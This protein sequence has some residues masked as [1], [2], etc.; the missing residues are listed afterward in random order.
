MFKKLILIAL[1]LTV[2]SF[3]GLVAVSADTDVF[4]FTQV[5]EGTFTIQ[6][7]APEQQV[8]K[9]LVEK[10]AKRYFYD[11][12]GTEAQYSLQMGSGTY[13]IGLFRQ[14]E[15]T[16]FEALAYE[17]VNVS[18]K[19]DKV[20]FL[21][22]AQLVNWSA[23]SNA[24]QLAQSITAGATTDQEKVE[25]IY[26]FIVNNISYDFNKAKTVQSG[27]VPNLDMV[28][29][30][31]NGIC[32][33]YSSLLA[34]M[35]RSQGIPTKL[36]MGNQSGSS[37]YHAWNEVLVDGQWKLIDATNDAA[38]IAAGMDVDMFKAPADYIGTQTY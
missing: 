36:V 27:Y 8:Y 4:D 25:A 1:L 16:Q 12:Q 26:D 6:Y 38:A 2:L 3:S 10:D 15:G 37:V 9:V 30:D 33:D 21:A 23:D 35:L 29:V 14:V 28:L 34:G 5:E 13:T 24:A 18:L 17:Q 31:G 32:Y 20:A 11:Y 7:A 22:S 19:N